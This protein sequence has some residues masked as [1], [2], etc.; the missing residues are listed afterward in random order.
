VAENSCVLKAL[1][2]EAKQ[3]LGGNVLEIRRF[4]FRVGRESRLQDMMSGGPESRRQPGSTPN[5]DLY[6]TETSHLLNVSREHFLIDE[7]DGLFLL[8]DRGSSC[9]TLVDGELVGGQRKG[10]WMKL[11]NQDVII[12]GTSESRF[13]FKFLLNS[14]W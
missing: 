7:R 1:T 4:P 13:I 9:G 3:A 11:Q 10:G 6:L 8:V 12:V 2:S 14:A 5:N